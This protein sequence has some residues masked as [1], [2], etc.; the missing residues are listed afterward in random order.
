MKNRKKVNVIIEQ[1]GKN[2]GWKS[3]KNNQQ[4]ALQM[5]KDFLTAYKNVKPDKHLE[6][7]RNYLAYIRN[8]FLIRN[9][10]H[11]GDYGTAC[12]ELETLAYYHGLYQV[13]IY[14]N[15]KKLLEEYYV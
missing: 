6:F 4:L 13:R 3:P 2:F 9:A 14:V 15:L 7:N 5:L 12:H 1:M 8:L 11:E 10:L